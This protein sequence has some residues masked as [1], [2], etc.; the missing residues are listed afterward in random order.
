MYKNLST[1]FAAII[2]FIPS[3]QAALPDFSD[4][5]EDVSPSVVKINTMSISEQHSS[6]QIPDIFRDLFEYGG[7][8]R[9]PAKKYAHRDRVLLFQ[10]TDIF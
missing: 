4:L 5:V 7:Q 3:V 10:M 1:Y 2:F 6:Q 9:S 8:P